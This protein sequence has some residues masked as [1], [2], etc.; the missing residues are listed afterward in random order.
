MMRRPRLLGMD[1]PVEADGLMTAPAAA[2]N[3]APIL[4]VLL[5]R[6]PRKGAVLE[7]ASGTGQHIAA[8]AA[9]RPDLTFH[10]TEPD[11]ARR[12]AIDAR[13][14]GLQNVA[15][16]GDL[17]AC[18]PGWAVTQASDAI[19]VVNL[20]H[21]ISDA[22]MAVLLDEAAKAL[23]PGGILAIYGPFLRDGQASSEGD[24]Q[25]DAALR[26]KDAEV[27]LKDIA[28][29]QTVLGVLDFTQEVVEMPANNVMLLARKAPDGRAPL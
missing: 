23:T 17:D 20:L 19:V 16:A 9:H 25:F 22:E 21:L 6:L 5:P 8:L 2:R 28:V 7:L 18:V 12:V 15:P 11:S 1:P 26:A 14:A 4:D 24:A 29:L 13:C 10:P 3:Q 27:G